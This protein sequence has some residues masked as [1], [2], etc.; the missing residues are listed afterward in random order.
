[1]QRVLDVTAETAKGGANRKPLGLP[2]P[3][4]PQPAPVRA[5]PS[6]TEKPQAPKGKAGRLRTPRAVA[7]GAWKNAIL[8]CANPEHK[9]WKNYGGRGITVCERWLASFEAFYAD[10]GPRPSPR[11]T[12]DRYP[13][14]D[15][16]YAPGNCRWATREQQAANMRPR[17]AR[18][19]VVINGVER[20]VRDLALEAGLPYATLYE[21]LK[22]GWNP[23]LALALPNGPHGHGS[24]VRHLLLGPNESSRPAQGHAVNQ[25]GDEPA[26]SLTSSPDKTSA[27]GTA[28]RKGAVPARQK[29]NA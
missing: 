10:L 25:A 19:S 14:N 7:R 13:D 21:R 3:T 15:G 8:R 18:L 22:E 16:P 24:K 6:D 28:A 2:L 23:A 4:E 26:S 11:H 5:C 1:M 12:L 29:E 27:R 9:D 17:V 20:T